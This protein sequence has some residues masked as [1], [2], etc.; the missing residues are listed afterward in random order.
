MERVLHFEE[1]TLRIEPAGTGRFRV[2]IAQSPYGSQA[3]PLVEARSGDN[4]ERFISAMEMAVRGR[5]SK[6]GLASPARDLATEKSEW[7]R[8]DLTPTQIGDRLFCLLFSRNVLETFLLSIGR[9]ETR[10]DSGL[11]IRLILDPTAP[12]ILALPWE[13]LYRADTC[14][15]LGR[16]P[17]TP[18]VRYLEVPRLA[19]PAPLV[20]SLRILA[21][22]A[23][24]HDQA[25][26]DLVKERERLLSAWGKEGRVDIE[27]LDKPTLLGLRTRLMKSRYHILHFM[28]HG[29]FNSQTGEGVLLFEDAQGYSASVSGRVLA[30][31]IKDSRWLRLVLLNAC[32]TAQLPRRR[33]QEP[34][35]GVASAL[36][37]GGLPAVIAM[38]YPISDDAALVFSQ[39]FYTALASGFPVDAAAAEARLAIHLSFPNSWE[40]ATPALY[41]SVPDG[42]ILLPADTEQSTDQFQSPSPSVSAS[43]IRADTVGGSGGVAIGGVGQTIQ[44]GIHLSNKGRT[45]EPSR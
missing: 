20:D 21:V 3:V 42:R 9:A 10:P 26:L 23:S 1:L 16:N 29:G 31:S 12:E 5:S 30:E 34:F 28:G 18:L 8:A 25:P 15:F 11:R 6:K 41:M 32:Q 17:L 44:G 19:A 33:G 39:H 4:F 40:W 27:F 7:L 22:C 36:L 2:Q 38:Q 14:D 37:L 13:L 35:S 45:D 24:P 43:G